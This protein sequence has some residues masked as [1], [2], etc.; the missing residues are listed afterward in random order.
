MLNKK[1]AYVQFATYV[2]LPAA[3]TLHRWLDILELLN[4]WMPNLFTIPGFQ[5]QALCT[6]IYHFLI[7]GMLRSILF[8][9]CQLRTENWTL[10]GVHTVQ[11]IA[12]YSHCLWHFFHVFYHIVFDTSKVFDNGVFWCCWWFSTMVRRDSCCKPMICWRQSRQ[13]CL[14]ARIA[15]GGCLHRMLKYQMNISAV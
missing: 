6:E 5:F 9:A 3:R 8:S 2:S 11:G 10:L 1:A 13:W 15:V 12:W 14:D 4:A 7:W